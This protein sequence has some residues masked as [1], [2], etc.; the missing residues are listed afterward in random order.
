MKRATY[1]KAASGALWQPCQN[2]LALRWYLIDAT[3]P[4]VLYNTSVAPEICF[5]WR[6][7]WRNR[8]SRRRHGVAGRVPELTVGGRRAWP[9]GDGAS[10][11]SDA[12]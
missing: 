4:D 6:W 7:K 5:Y 3:V 12:L 2:H 11:G 1:L 9:A 10:M 8:S